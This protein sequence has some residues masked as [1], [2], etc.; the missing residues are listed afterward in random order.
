MKTRNGFVS[1]SSA[2]SFIVHHFNWKSK[3]ILDAKTIKKLLK[4]G[5]K[6]THI[7]HPSHL[8]NAD[9]KDKDIWKAAIEKDGTII[10][11]NYGYWV[12]CNQDEV[13]QFLVK[14]DI[15]FIAT[16]HYGHVTYLFHKG[17]KHLMVF[18]NYG[19][20]VET[21]HY[22]KKWEEITKGWKEYGNEPYQRITIKDILEEK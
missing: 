10:S 22:D 4:Y 21:Y 7:S 8:D 20:E 14:N 16:G 11:K 19:A 13:I 1:N 17:D 15:G 5:F 6:E 18:R 9:Y 3:G 12:S 2:S